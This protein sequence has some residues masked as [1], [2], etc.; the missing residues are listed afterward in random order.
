MKALA[1]SLLFRAAG[2]LVA[3]FGAS[4]A[5]AAESG[6]PAIQGTLSQGGLI[7]MQ[8]P[9][10][11]AA[12]LDGVALDVLPNG[13]TLAG[14]GRDAKPSA[15]LEVTG[16]APCSRTLAIAKREYNIQ[17]VD[18][19]PS[20]T[21]TP[22]QAQLDRIRREAVKVAAARAPNLERPELLERV[23]GQ[24]TWPLLGRISGV[25]GSQRVYNGK[26]G[27]P[28]YGVDV[29]RPTGTPVRAPAPGVVT[30]AE[31]DLFY[32]GGT[33]ILDHGYNL[34]S[35][36]LHMSALDVKVG[37]QLDAGDLIGAVGATGR[38]TG[39]HLDWRMNWRKQ[40]IDPALLV[41]PQPDLAE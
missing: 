11:S 25:Y 28:H 30:L 33:V 15:Q 20:R 4:V 36:F 10:G 27:R 17:R 37:D 41:P 38:A 16:P 8:L 5:G 3:V 13:M 21:V 2:A 9:P 19:V 12:T 40:R 14:F 35:T 24:F 26:P 29:A 23:L 18:G 32:S 39:P 6:C 31:P 34:S 1:V 22:P 7:W